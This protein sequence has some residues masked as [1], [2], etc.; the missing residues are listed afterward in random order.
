MPD[1]RGR[2]CR[3]RRRR[4]S[5]ATGAAQPPV[6]R[7]QVHG[8]GRGGRARGGR[9]GRPWTRSARVRG[10]RHRDRDPA[11]PD[12]P[13]VHVVQP[14]RRID[15]APLRRNGARSRDLEAPRRTDGRDDP[16]GE[17]GG[18]G[19][20]VPHLASGRA[21]GA[22]RRG[23][24]A[25]DTLPQLLGKRVLVVDDNATNR[26]IVTRHARAWQMEPVAVESGAEALALLDAGERFDVGVLDMMMPL[27]G[28]GR[29][30]ARDPASSTAARAAA[31][32][33]DLARTG[34]AG[35][36]R[37]AS[38]TRSSQSRSAHR[39]STTRSCGCL[40]TTMVPSSAAEPERLGAAGSSL[41]IL[42]AEDNVVNQKV[43][44]RLLERLGYSGG[45]G[46]ERVGGDRSARA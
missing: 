27:H 9:S 37:A 38:S 24:R 34:A 20:D 15:D 41:R 2:A 39:S 16:G 23:R 40:Q 8:G 4:R 11:G 5:P 29:A 12:G 14:G 31:S 43:A 17:R 18:Q 7:G 3:D 22:R 19:L 33:P 26:E 1:R 25:E 35:S 10:S 32:A 13:S 30:C 45:C 46:V 36:R 28:R 42:L 6:E 21:G 44:L